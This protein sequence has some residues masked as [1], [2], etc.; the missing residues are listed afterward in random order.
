[1]S[2]FEAIGLVLA[3]FPIVE[4][5]IKIYAETKPG[6]TAASLLRKLKTETIIYD[7][8]VRNLLDSVVPAS[9][10]EKLLDRSLVDL[11]DLW[12]D[13]DLQQALLGRLGTIK[14]RH[15]LE[16]LVDMNQ[17]LKT[18]EVELTN[19]SRGTVWHERLERSAGAFQL[20]VLF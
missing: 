17:R 9:T 11:P 5:A 14:S 20:T 2:G 16:M 7:Q 4:T 8:L 10:V 12:K 1:M 18:I 3:L 19:I 15:L 6:H 13:G